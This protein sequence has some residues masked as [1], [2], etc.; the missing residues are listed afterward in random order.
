MKFRSRKCKLEYR[1]K[2]EMGKQ[3]PSLDR[4][5]KIVEE[6]ES[7]NINTIEK[8]KKKKSITLK[9]VNGALKQSINAHGPI[10]KDLIG[11]ASKRVY[12]SILETEQEEENKVSLKDVFIGFFISS[13]FFLIIYLFI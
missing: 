6:F 5:I 7:D 4:I 9:K 11:S 13:L 1:L 12:G 10:T 8:L 3:T 2:E